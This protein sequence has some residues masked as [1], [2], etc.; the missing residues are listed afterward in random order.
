VATRS[1][2]VAPV[3]QRGL[4][5]GTYLEIRPP[6][7]SRAALARIARQAA[8]QLTR[9]EA[10]TLHTCADPVCGMLFL[11]P[12]G[13][14]RWCAADVCGVRNRVRAHRQRRGADS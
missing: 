8:E 12:G 6:A 3:S 5:I 11:D 4:A 2:H 10:M 13:R 14:R 1:S 9:P 7:T